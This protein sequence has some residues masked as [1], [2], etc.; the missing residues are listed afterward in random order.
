VKLPEENTK[1]I[2]QDI[3][4]GNDFVTRIPVAQEI[5]ARINKSDYIKFLNFCIPTEQLSER[6]CSIQNRRKSLP[7]IHQIRG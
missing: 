3:G 6:R 4:I 7:D 1:K 5:R 2:L